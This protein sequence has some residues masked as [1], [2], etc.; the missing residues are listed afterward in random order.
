[1]KTRPLAE[2]R[3][4]LSALLEEVAGTHETVTITRNGIPAAV[5]VS[6]EDYESVMETL[7]LAGDAEDRAR[8]AEA[9]GSVA[10][11][12]VTTAEEMGRLIRARVE[13]EGEPGEE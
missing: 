1:M 8:L 10:T 11:G 7:A 6:A 13:R 2:A 9:E 3:N 4:H 12:D 5:V